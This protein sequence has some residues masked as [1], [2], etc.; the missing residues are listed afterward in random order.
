MMK[1]INDIEMQQYIAG[2]LSTSGKEKVQMHLMKCRECSQRWRKAVDLWDVLGQWDIDTIGH[3]VA[4]RV[5]ALAEKENR[6]KTKNDNILKLWK[7]YLP[8]VLRVAASI[9]IAM[10]VGYKLGRYSVTGFTP[11]AAVSTGS[12]EYLSALSLEW[13]SEL[14]WFVLDNQSNGSQQQ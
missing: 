5:I 11:K 4:D 12:P 2:K 1:H 9:I 10:G 6:N 8:A 14:T 3:N 7:E 13:S